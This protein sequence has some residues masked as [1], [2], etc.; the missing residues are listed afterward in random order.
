[1]IFDFALNIHLNHGDN[2]LPYC[3]TILNFALNIH[4]NDV[5]KD[6]NKPII[7]SGF[8]FCIENSHNQCPHMKHHIHTIFNYILLVG[9]LNT[10]CIINID[11]QKLKVC[12]HPQNYDGNLQLKSRN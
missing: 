2:I 11:L 5:C 4:L 12:D 6:N 9:F 10:L 3:L 1:M 7:S 8:W